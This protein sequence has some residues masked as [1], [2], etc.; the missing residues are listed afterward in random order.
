MNNE[1]G[2]MYISMGPVKY[3]FGTLF[4]IITARK[5]G[6]EMPITLIT[7]QNHVT[8][9]VFAKRFNITPIKVTM[10]KG[11]P[12]G[13]KT[14]LYDYS[15]Y[16]KSIYIDSDTIICDDLTPIF[17]FVGR[18]V[19][20]ACGK[21]HSMIAAKKEFDET[22]KFC[23]EQPDDVRD[24]LSVCPLSMEWYN[25]G[26]IAFVKSK[27]TEEFF[28]SYRQEWSTYKQTDEAP[29]HRALVKTNTPINLLPQRFNRGYWYVD[30]KKKDWG[31]T[32]VL[33]RYR[34]LCG[35]LPNLNMMS[36]Y[37]KRFPDI[38]K[39]MLNAFR[40]KIDKNS[41]IKRVEHIIKKEMIETTRPPKDARVIPTVH[42]SRKLS[43]EISG[44]NT[45]GKI[46][47]PKW[48]IG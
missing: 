40:Y 25:G 32:V 5:A 33:H 45:Q 4:S 13:M 46:D 24:T 31:D 11:E 19:K 29:F 9:D 27:K 18:D 3:L 34:G 41:L 6:N 20:L 2:L 15:M 35:D 10:P 42:K 23:R 43:T 1:T 17:D 26:V 48:N 36:M 22:G 16:Y 37:R 39:F 21:S 44:F 47:P 12:E 8:L 30:K 38:Y 14:L 28:K 7:D